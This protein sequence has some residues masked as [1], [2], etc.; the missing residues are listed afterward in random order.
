M[1]VI[2]CCAKNTH[3]IETEINT[4]FRKKF[5]KHDDGNEYFSG[6]PD[7]MKDTMWE[8]VKKWRGK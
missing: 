2:E 8:I 4:E 3:A 6:N 5:T 1:L 7:E